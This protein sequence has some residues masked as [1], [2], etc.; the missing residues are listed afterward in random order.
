MVQQL[1]TWMPEPVRFVEP[2]GGFFVWLEL[3]KGID[4]SAL[5]QD[6]REASLLLQP[7]TRFSIAS[8]F[9]NCLRLCFA[10]HPEAR[11][12]EGCERLAKLLHRHLCLES[13]PV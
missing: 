13:N 3:P 7:G 4:N 1:R 6:A 10:C 12:R 9:D 2:H 11:I 5:I 8:H